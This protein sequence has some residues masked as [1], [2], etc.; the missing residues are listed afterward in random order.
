MNK[1]ELQQLRIS[2]FMGCKEFD[3]LFDQDTTISGDNGTGKSTIYD[4][5]LWLLFGKNHRDEKD[6]CIKNTVDKSLNRQDHVVEAT[7]IINDKETVLTRVY[8]EKHQKQ[9]GNETPEFVGHETDFF[10]NEVPHKAG[11]YKSFVD[12]IIKEDVFKL[13]TNVYAFNEMDWQAMRKVLEKI[14]GGKTDEQIAAGNE[15]F[16]KLIRALS[17]K[18]FDAYSKQLAVRKKDIKEK[19]EKIPVQI[20]EASKAKT[21][22]AVFSDQTRL[23]QIKTEIKLLQ[24]QKEDIS[25]KN[26]LVFDK[27]NEEQ[28][29]LSDLKTAL[30]EATRKRTSESQKQGAET[31]S[32]I[33]AIEQEVEL[34]KREAASLESSIKSLQEESAQIQDSIVALRQ[35]FTNINGSVAPIIDPADCNCPTCKQRLP[36]DVLEDKEKTL[37]ENFNLDKLKKLEQINEKGG[38]LKVREKEVQNKIADKTAQLADTTSKGEEILKKLEQTKAT[39]A[40]ALAIKDDTESDEEIKLKATIDCFFVTPAPTV[41]FGDLNNKIAALEKENDNCVS[42]LAMAEANKKQDERIADLKEQES[43]LSKELASVEK[44]EFVMTAF[45]KVKMDSIEKAVND[46]FKYTTFQLFERQINGGEKETCI[47]MYGGVPYSSVNTAGRIN[48]GI[49][50]INVLTK[51]FQ[52]MAPVFIDNTESVN[53]IIDTDCQLIKLQ[54]SQSPKLTIIKSNKQL[55][56][57]N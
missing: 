18:D 57:V 6:F 33:I 2:N 32:A 41:Y 7:L 56:Y 14:A 49:D 46:M 39:L 15:D 27:I 29:Q 9:R 36:D 22:V 50:I 21:D 10:V 34:N 26:K 20:S 3:Q 52:C 13:I 19:L 55:N 23:D 1:I 16:E 44:T 40:S 28:K 45:T 24:D 51:H 4:A 5:F 42:A 47:P 53:K 17:G 30:I 38:S 43:A 35:E 37:Q 11:E 12:S 54:V 25:K 31:K 8:R 48:M